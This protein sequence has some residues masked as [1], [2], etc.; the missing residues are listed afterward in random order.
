MRSNWRRAYEA[1]RC[2]ERETWRLCIH[3][4]AHALAAY[5]LGIKL[6]NLVV[7]RGVNDDSMS[8]Q[9]YC[10]WKIRDDDPRSLVTA[11]IAGPSA[12]WIFFDVSRSADSQDYRD[13]HCCDATSCESR[14][15]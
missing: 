5:T 9:G 11:A 7:G 8:L 10:A 4:S 1:A 13:A 15:R 2:E 6:K 3:E 12:D 14:G